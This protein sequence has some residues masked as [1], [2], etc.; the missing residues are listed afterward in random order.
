MSEMPTPDVTLKSFFADNERFADVFNSYL[1][2]K[3]RIF[4]PDMLESADT[5]YSESIRTKK[6]VIKVN[7]YRDTVRKSVGTYM[8]I[9]GIENQSHIN[10]AMPLRKILY[11]IL[12]YCDE[13]S[14]EK[15]GQDA[16]WTLEERLSSMRSDKKLTPI[17]TVVF[18]TGT[19]PWD[20]PR[21]LRDMF[22]PDDRLK[23]LIPDYP[24]YLIDLGHDD[25]LSFSN[26]ELE[27]LRQA[28]HDLCS[29]DLNKS[30][31]TL[32]ASIL[33]LFGILTGMKDIYDAAQKKKGE[34]VKMC[35]I[36]E[37]RDRIKFAKKDEEIAKKEKEISRRDN[38]I[39][40]R[41]IEISKMKKDI[42]RKDEVISEK[43]EEIARL[44]AELE[45]RR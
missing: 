18:Y 7:R 16:A 25:K 26:R 37:E 4:D 21:S 40:K 3:D 2:N 12:G 8:A 17:I 44:K 9:L 45:A 20:G 6:D 32:E 24:L 41:D 5:A 10:Y 38:E 33:G 11:D 43:D 15:A 42:S 34:R 19:K 31:L 22:E 1:F 29:G 14:A 23:E 36:M 39:S 27:E 35:D 13:I 30:S 28:M